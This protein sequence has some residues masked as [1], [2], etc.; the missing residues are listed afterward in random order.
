MSDVVV[1]MVASIHTTNDSNFVFKDDY[2]V[3][4]YANKI[5]TDN[6]LGSSNTVRSKSHI[7]SFGFITSTTN[8]KHL[9]FENV[10]R[11]AMTLIKRW[12]IGY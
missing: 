2:P 10:S 4:F 1:S 3:V 7:I 8:K 9:V 6:I 5:I 12:S 11:M